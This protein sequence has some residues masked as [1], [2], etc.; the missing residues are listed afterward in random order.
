MVG[1]LV[2]ALILLVRR[3]GGVRVWMEVLRLLFCVLAVLSLG[4]WFVVVLKVVLVVLLVCV[5]GVQLL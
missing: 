3:V 4:G 1:G 2:L 5:V